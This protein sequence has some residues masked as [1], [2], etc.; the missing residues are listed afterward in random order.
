[1]ARSKYKY[2]EGRWK[3]KKKSIYRWGGT[4]LKLVA[5]LLREQMYA[6]RQ[7]GLRF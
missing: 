6:Q 4:K 1:M 3:R 7:R 5:L 2:H